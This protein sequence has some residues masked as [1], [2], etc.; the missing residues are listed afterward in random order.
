MERF[1]SLRISS[2]PIFK[3]FW[4]WAVASYHMFYVILVIFSMANLDWLHKT[5]AYAGKNQTSKMKSFA[6]MVIGFQPLKK[7]S[8]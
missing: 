2:S 3:N 6:K 1:Y 7:A 8:S 4:I 5:E